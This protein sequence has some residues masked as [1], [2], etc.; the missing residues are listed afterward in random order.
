M[1]CKFV[2]CVQRHRPISLLKPC[3]VVLVAETVYMVLGLSLGLD[4]L[5]PLARLEVDVLPSAVRVRSN[6]DL[7]GVYRVAGTATAGSERTASLVPNA[8]GGMQ[9]WSSKDA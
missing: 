2:I 8:C 3:V 1:P 6:H 9:G 4:V 7:H 5:L